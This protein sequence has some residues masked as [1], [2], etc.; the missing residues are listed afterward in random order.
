VP[1]LLLTK[2][3]EPQLSVSGLFHTLLLGV[4]PRLCRLAAFAHFRAL[5]FS[6][7]RFLASARHEETSLGASICLSSQVRSK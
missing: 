6:H 5:S 7:G 1:R 4:W 3:L 2:G